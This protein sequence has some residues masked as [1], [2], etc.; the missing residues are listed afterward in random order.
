MVSTYNLA[1][2]CWGKT[3]EYD[4][5]VRQLYLGPSAELITKNDLLGS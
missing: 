3:F 4:D 5:W 1:R 2:K